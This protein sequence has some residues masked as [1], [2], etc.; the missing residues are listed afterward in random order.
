MIAF[1]DSSP[2]KKWDTCVDP[3][4][5]ACS[6][7]TQYEGA[8]HASSHCNAV[9][10]HAAIANATASPCSKPDTCKPSGRPASRSSGSEIDGMPR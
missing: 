8:C 1:A 6:P 4:D 9:S 7:G 2:D 10:I 3:V 5:G